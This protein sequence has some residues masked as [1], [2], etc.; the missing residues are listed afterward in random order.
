[1]HTYRVKLRGI[2]VSNTNKTIVNENLNYS[3]L[4]EKTGYNSEASLNP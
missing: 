1:M 2:Q 4:H 3:N